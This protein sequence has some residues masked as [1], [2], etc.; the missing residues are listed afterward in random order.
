MKKSLYGAL[1]VFLTVCFVYIAYNFSRTEG[2][3]SYLIDDAYIHLS[4]AKNF[5]LYDV[6]GVT[7]Y[8]TVSASSSPLFTLVISAIIAVVGDHHIMP[9]IFNLVIG[10]WMVYF[11]WRYYSSLSKNNVFVFIAISLTIMYSLMYLQ[12]LLG[13]EHVLHAFVCCVFIFFL[14]RNLS[15][16]FTVKSDVYWMLFTLIP[17]GL[18]RFESM[19]LFFITSFLLLV[20]RKYKLALLVVLYGFI[21]VFLFGIINKSIDGHFFPNSVVVKG[22]L[23]WFEGDVIKIVN[24]YILNKIFL[25][26]TF[27][28]LGFLSFSTLVLL[29]FRKGENMGFQDFVKRDFSLLL[30]VFVFLGQLLF[31]EVRTHF[32]Y[33]AYLMLM[34]AMVLAPYFVHNFYKHNIYLKRIMFVSFVGHLVMLGYKNVVAQSMLVSGTA[35]VYEQQIQSAK[36]LKKFYNTDKVIANDI[37][38]ISY[39]S[40]VHLLDIIGLGS[41]IMM[42]YNDRYSF[43]QDFEDFLQSYSLKNDYKIAV[44]Y[45][46]W[47]DGHLPKTWVEVGQFILQDNHNVASNVVSVYAV[48]P[49]YVVDLKNNMRLFQWNNRVDVRILE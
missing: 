15:R 27:Y 24:Y 9:L 36:F 6:W 11:L 4:I 21:P 43:H 10:C 17:M 32:R 18:I 13:M 8:N 38:A 47:F 48:R 29:L 31:G 3:F 19:L 41:S 22:S 49:E 37:G 23:L 33:E 26:P 12:V 40:D 28:K 20:I 2:H 44:V 1:G 7:A 5:A 30:V 16:D 39:Y 35:N 46:K 25:N 45:K 42:P 14:Q 34:F